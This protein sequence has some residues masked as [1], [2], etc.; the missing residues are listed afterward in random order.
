[1]VLF[2]VF[3]YI[4]FLLVGV[5]LLTCVFFLY[6]TWTITDALSFCLFADLTSEIKCSVWTGSLEIWVFVLFPTVNEIWDILWVIC[7]A[8][9]TCLFYVFL[10][11]CYMPKIWTSGVSLSKRPSQW[12]RTIRWKAR[13][14]IRLFL[15][16]LRFS[17]VPLF[18][19][20]ALYSWPGRSRRNHDHHHLWHALSSNRCTR[21][22]LVMSIARRLFHWFSHMASAIWYHGALCHIIAI[23]RSVAMQ[24]LLSLIISLFLSHQCSCPQLANRCFLLLIHTPGTVFHCTSLQRHL[25]R[26][27]REEIWPVFVQLHFLS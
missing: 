15:V 4:C 25:Y 14:C 20:T 8:E 7:R 1:M 22:F 12:E 5:L 24:V 19:L 11:R 10:S 26:V 17:L 27:S 13:S 16:T 3:E 23:R 6:W 9:D 2:V 18:E 21:H